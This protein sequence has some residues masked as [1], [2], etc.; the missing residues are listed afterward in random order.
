VRTSLL[1]GLAV[2]LVLLAP[3]FAPPGGAYVSCLWALRGWT[4][5]AAV[6]WFIVLRQLGRL[7]LR[8]GMRHTGGRLRAGEG[9]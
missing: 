7:V 4:T 8:L 3:C 9:R 1:A 6:L 5:M 2:G